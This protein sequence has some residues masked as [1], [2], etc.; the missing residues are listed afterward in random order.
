MGR[1]ILKLN[2]KGF[3]EYAEK[4][5]RLG[6]DLKPIFTDALQQAAETITEDT[7]EAISAGNLPRGGKYSTGKTEASIIKNPKV[8]WSGTIAEIPVG[9]DFAK[10]GAGGYLITGTPRMQPDKELNRIYKQK[11]Y[12]TNIRKDMT[13]IFEDEI[14]K[15]MGGQNGR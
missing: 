12:M 4:L 2:T 7:M 8:T 14:Q 10:P 5:E 13:D 3:D 15:R 11:R 6:V 9:F 1:N